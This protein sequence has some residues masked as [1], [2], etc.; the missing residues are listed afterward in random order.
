MYL[1]VFLVWMYR[2]CYVKH[3][4]ISLALQR[5]TIVMITLVKFETNLKIHVENITYLTEMYISQRSRKYLNQVFIQ[6]LSI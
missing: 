2:A 4:E 6:V 3:F 5:G 1:K